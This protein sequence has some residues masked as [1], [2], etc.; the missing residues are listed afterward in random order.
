GGFFEVLHYAEVL[1]LDAKMIS[2]DDNYEAF[3]S[4]KFTSFFKQYT[5]GVASAGNLGLSIGIMS[6]KLGFTV[7][8]YMSRDATAW[9]KKLLREKGAT[10]HEIAG[11]FSDA[12]K[13]AREEIQQ[14]PNGDCV[15]DEDFKY[16]FLRYR[17]AAL[18]VNDL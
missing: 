13:A 3:S 15:D 17:A 11:D 1:A 12:I 9:K 8:V 18:R 14:Y 7:H 10:V 5:I 16:L 2:K 4:E 6:A